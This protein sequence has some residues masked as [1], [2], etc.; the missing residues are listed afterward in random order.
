MKAEKVNNI[1]C[2]KKNDFDDFRQHW[3][4]TLASVFVVIY[5]EVFTDLRFFI[6]LCF[7]DRR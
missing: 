2:V 7:R 6:Y 4:E 1:S 3:L 5:N